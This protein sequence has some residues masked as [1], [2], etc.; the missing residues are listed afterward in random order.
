M[1]L[2]LSVI[3][4]DKNFPGPIETRIEIP[5]IYDEVFICGKQLSYFE[6][7]HLVEDLKH[8]LDMILKDGK[9]I[10]KHKGE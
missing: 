5:Q 1:R 2:K 8:D 3:K 7:E 6:L 9:K 4:N 10:Y